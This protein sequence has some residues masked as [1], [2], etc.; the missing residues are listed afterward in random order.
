[1][2][3]FRLY[4]LNASGGIL[5]FAEFEAPDDEAALALADEHQGS[6]A[7]EL[8]CGKRK[9]RHFPA[10]TAAAESLSSDML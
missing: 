8:W 3:Y 6:N 1:M 9:V 10:L 5:R 7:L 4:F 2:Q